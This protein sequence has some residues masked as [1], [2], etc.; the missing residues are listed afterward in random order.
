MLV[1]KRYLLCYLLRASSLVKDGGY[2]IY[3]VCSLLNDQKHF[4]LMIKNVFQLRIF[5]D[6]LKF[7]LVLKSN[8][9]L[10]TPNSLKKEEELTDFL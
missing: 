2:I 3:C 1:V 5:S 4:F 7:G 10:V 9:F 8:T 6:I